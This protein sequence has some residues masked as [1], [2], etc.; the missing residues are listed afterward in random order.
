MKYLIYILNFI[1]VLSANY[2]DL[3]DTQLNPTNNEMTASLVYNQNDFNIDEYKIK[4]LRNK[5]IDL[6]RELSVSAKIEL[7]DIFHIKITD[8]NNQRWEAPEIIDPAYIDKEKKYQSTVSFNDYGFTYTANPFSFK[9][10]K[11]GEA[12]YTWGEGNFFFSENLI[13]F[14]TFLNNDDIYGFG[15]RSRKFKLEKGIYTIW[16]NDTATPEDDGTGGKN[17]Y[18]AQPFGL[19]RTKSGQFVG[20]FFLNI[21]AQDFVIN[22]TDKKT[23][24]EHRTIGGV[25]DLYIFTGSTPEEVIRKYQNIV[26]KPIIP[27]I[28]GLGWH[29]CRWGY[30]TDEQVE[31]IFN[32]YVSEKIPLD[33]IWNDIDYMEDYRDFSVSKKRFGNIGNIIDTVHQSGRRY[34]PILDIGIPVNENDKY[35]NLGMEM[36]TFIKSNYTKTPLKNTVWPGVCHYP[37]WF[38]PNATKFWKTGLEDLNKLLDF[39]GIWIDMNE[40]SGFVDGEEEATRTAENNKYENIPYVPGNNNIVLD[41]HGLS[42][43]SILYGDS[44]IMT[45]YN[46]KPMFSFYQSKATNEY[47]KSKDKRPFI[48]S[49]SNVAGSHRYTF[50]WLG[51]N[52][53]NFNSMKTSIPGIFNYQMFGY[54]VVGSDVCGFVGDTNDKLCSRWHTLGAFYPFS[55]NHNDFNSISQEPW[56]IG[57]LTLVSAKKAL[58]LRYSLIRYLYSQIYLM[59]LNGGTVFKPVFFEFPKD[60]ESF[61]HIDETAMFG[62]AFMIVPVFSE[63]EDDIMTYFPNANW[64]EYATGTNIIDYNNNGKGTEIQLSGKFDKVHL[65]MRGGSIVPRQ[66]TENPLI[67]TTTELRNVNTEILINPDHMNNAQGD[68]IFDEGYTN[69]NQYIHVNMIMNYNQLFFNKSTDFTDYKYKDINISKVTILRADYLSKNLKAQIQD[70]NEKVYYTDIKYLEDRVEIN[71][72]KMKFNFLNIK[73]I[74][75]LDKNFFEA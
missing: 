33:V 19:H 49:R 29:Q 20:I 68:V 46:A 23:S 21:N 72:E 16:P 71:L 3:I 6:I 11:N 4:E 34:I 31:S 42:V 48:I 47:L 60:A 66:E 26:G 51:D 67:L 13:V 15:E 44:N 38:N 37:D 63:N 54:S 35:Y 41:G 5:N 50:H 36:N 8:K 17:L 74:Y 7:D 45:T 52:F 14:E 57:Q 43:N 28:W 25:I 62:N 55:R 73:N 70:V 30:Q 59:S 18:G 58:L 65:Y 22:P 69:D 32:R 56:A 10:T 24:L 61:N 27:P 1:Y 64:N 9:L 75:L 2:Y 12:Y 40:P 39:D 53:S